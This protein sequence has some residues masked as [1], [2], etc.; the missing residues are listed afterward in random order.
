MGHIQA[1]GFYMIHQSYIKIKYG[2][3]YNWYAAADARNVANIGWHVATRANFITLETYAGGSTVAGG[4]LKETGT[5]Y[6]KTPN[7]GATN[8]FNF[9]LRGLGRRSVTNGIFEALTEVGDVWSSDE[10]TLDPTKGR[11]AQLG[12]NNLQSSV[13]NIV[14]LKEDG[15]SIRLIKDSTSLSDGESGTYTG[16]DGKVYRTI[17]IGTQ[18]WVADNLT[19][20]KYRNGDAISEVTDDA[21]W[22]ALTTGALCA[23]N[24]DWDNV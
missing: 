9:N 4:H 5:T 6:W 12:V 2:L 22:A 21:A 16:N 13:T 19:E 14:A 1:T 23:Y 17:C 8:E 10:Y 3:F 20:T 24:N 15:K 11:Y 18:E 7:T